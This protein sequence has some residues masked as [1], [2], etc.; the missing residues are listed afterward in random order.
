MKFRFSAISR[1]T[2]EHNVGDKN[3]KHISTDIILHC[4]DNL[5]KRKYLDK[6]ELPTKEG[7]K[8]MT[9]AFVQGLLANLHM[10]HQ[11]GYWDSAEHLRYIIAEL[12]KGFV[13]PAD[14]S[15]ADFNREA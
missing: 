4:S 9:N 6:K 11:K 3:S 12:E 15:E 14:V 2:L 5:D 10:A 7:I 1:I 13:A 8:P